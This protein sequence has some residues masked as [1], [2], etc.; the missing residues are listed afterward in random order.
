MDDTIRRLKAFEA[1]GA[2]VLYAPGLNTLE[3]LQQVTAEITRPFNV[4]APPFKGVTVDEFAEAGAKR[5]S[6]GG[7]LNLAAVNPV[8]NAGKEMLEHGTFNWVKQMAPG[9]DVKSLISD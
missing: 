4:L 7:A 5:I 6:I 9:K 1:A 8:L 2:H 3:S